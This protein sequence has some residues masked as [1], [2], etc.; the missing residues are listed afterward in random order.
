MTQRTDIVAAMKK[1]WSFTPPRS[2]V[3]MHRAGLFEYPNVPRNQWPPLIKR[4]SSE[5]PRVFLTVFEVD[6]ADVVARQE[7]RNTF[8]TEMLVPGLVPIGGDGSGDAWCFDTRTKI[9]GMTPIVHVPHDG[10]GG[11]YV[12]PSFAGF[13]Y[14]L[15]LQNLQYLH[16]FESWKLTHA[17]LAAVTRRSA[18]SAAPWLLRRWRSEV[19]RTVRADGVSG[20][21]TY[22]TLPQLLARD[23]AFAR[24]PPGEHDV[25]KT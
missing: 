15:I 22:K 3:E 12:A 13:V 24:L 17:D 8:V 18:E 20:W 2:Y 4:W 6:S 11:V 5:P 9:G 19:E 25:F 14:Y 7:H 23:P 1:T 21:P 16:F 10:G